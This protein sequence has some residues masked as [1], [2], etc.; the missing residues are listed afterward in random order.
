MLLD[1]ENKNYKVHEWISKYTTEGK[2]DVVTGYFTIGA[3]AFISDK[4]NAYGIQ[5]TIQGMAA[6]F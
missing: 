3:L 1:N 6:G 2:M 5:R 4:H